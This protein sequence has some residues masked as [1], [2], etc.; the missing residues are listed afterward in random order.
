MEILEVNKNKRWK[1]LFFDKKISIKS[2]ADKKEAENLG[3]K[4]A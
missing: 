4:G 3:R 1:V 2:E